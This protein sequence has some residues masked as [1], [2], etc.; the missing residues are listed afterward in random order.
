MAF[1]NS[2]NVTIRSTTTLWMTDTSTSSNNAC[3]YTRHFGSEISP[4]RHASRVP[5]SMLAGIG[6]LIVVT[7]AVRFSN[8][9][10]NIP[11]I[12]CRSAK[13]STGASARLL[14]AAAR[15]WIYH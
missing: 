2:S 6:V 12:W 9:S 5:S 11:A 7:A 3:T 15:D 10:F 8:A 4:F 13:A 14:I 1:N